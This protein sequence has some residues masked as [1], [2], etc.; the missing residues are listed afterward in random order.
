MK[1]K[2]QLMWVFL[3]YEPRIIFHK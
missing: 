2:N 3:Y 1:Q